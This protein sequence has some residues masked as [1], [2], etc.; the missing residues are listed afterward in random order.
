[1]YGFD[2]WVCMLGI[3]QLGLEDRHWTEGKVLYVWSMGN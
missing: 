2:S 1:M 3:K